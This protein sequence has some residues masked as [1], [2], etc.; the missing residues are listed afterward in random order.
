MER[1]YK[2]LDNKMEAV[3]FTAAGT[4][5]FLNIMLK[6]LKLKKGLLIAAIV[7]GDEAIIPN[8]NDMILEGDRVIVVARSLFL[9]DLNDI[10]KD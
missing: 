4:T 8:G 6:N 2:L 1:L 10:L 9:D 3:E 5:R 7:R